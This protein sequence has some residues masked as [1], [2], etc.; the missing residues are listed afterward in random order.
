M[1]K[2][3]AGQRWTVFAFDETTNLPVT[4]DAA[5]ITGNLYL[6]GVLNAIDDT[7]PTETEDGQYDFTITQA[8]SNADHIS[9]HAESSTA[10]VQ[11]I[12]IPGALYTR[13]PAF[14]TFVLGDAAGVASGLHTTTN[15]KVDAVQTDIGD[16]SGRTNDQSLL[17]VLGV[18][19]VAGK[20]LH[21]LLVTDRL[22]HA[23]YGL[24]ALQTLLANVG[25]V[26]GAVWVD[27]TGANTNTVDFVDGVASNPVST[28]AAAKTIA[29]S[30]ELKIFLV[31]PGSSITLATA[32]DN[33]IFDA[34][35]ATIALGGQSINNSVFRGAII[36]GNDD[37]SNASHPQFFDCFF[38]ASTLGQF[39]MT[40]CYFGST[41]TLA[42]T[43]DYYLHQCFS[44]IAG[45]GTPGLDFGAALGVCNVNIRDYSGGWEIQ[46][47]GNVGADKMTVEGRGQLILNANCNPA[48]GPE[49]AIRGTISPLTDNVAGGFVLGGGTISDDARYDTGQINA[50]VSD[51]IKTD[52]Y[53]L[54]GQGA[55]TVTPTLEEAIMY[56]FKQFRNKEEQTATEYAL[57][58]D[59][60]TTKDQKATVSDDGT[61]FTKGEI[62]TGA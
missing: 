17:E 3:V 31:L 6:D 50:E 46:N 45:L 53:T 49:I 20:D 8:E 54:P 56:L 12:G 32:Y 47:M 14:S 23:N 59:A 62:A 41:I 48:N 44:G 28:I 24:S 36:T 33:Y 40:R 7:N 5:N 9:I 39:V 16:F 55:P 1:Q 34:C 21:T 10:N 27:T 26:G 35:H 18:P 58:D 60:G 43:G 52:T 4:G 37:G 11:V 30:L 25:Y 13:P 51:V 57:Y 22:D 61:T 38:G 15:G 42:Q 19:D 2:N 29:D